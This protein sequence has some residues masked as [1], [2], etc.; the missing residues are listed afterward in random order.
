[1]RRRFFNDI[2]RIAERQRKPSPL[3]D[4]IAVQAAVRT[5]RGAVQ[6]DKS[7]F[8]KSIGGHCFDYRCVV[9][10]RYKTNILA[11]ALMRIE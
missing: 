2:D 5:D 10:V 7:A 3:P 4:G 6:V 9:A 11:I 8:G 1:M